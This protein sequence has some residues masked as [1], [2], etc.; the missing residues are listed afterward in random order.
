[1]SNR[2]STYLAVVAFV[3]VAE[4]TVGSALVLVAEDSVLVAS[5]NDGAGN[6]AGDEGNSREEVEELHFE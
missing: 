5:L 6:G 3:T 1:M 2:G 4:A